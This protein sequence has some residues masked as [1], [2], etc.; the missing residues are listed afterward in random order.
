M[1]YLVAGVSLGLVGVF[2][3]VPTLRRW[4]DTAVR[5]RLTEVIVALAKLARE[6]KRLATIVL[7]CST[8]TLGSALAIRR[9]ARDEVAD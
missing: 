1:L 4:L 7:G 3:I 2:L 5:P 8:T 9:V 6:P